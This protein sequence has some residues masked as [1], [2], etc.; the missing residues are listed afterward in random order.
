MKDSKKSNLPDIKTSLPGP[1]SK[2]LIEK[3][4]NL[5]GIKNLPN[6][7][8]NRGNGCII[9]D[10]DGNEF[11]VFSQAAC[12]TGYSNS[13]I[14]N[15]SI[16]Q[17]K[18]RII[19]GIAPPLIDCTEKLLSNLHGELS[20]GRVNFVVSGTESVELAVSFARA[21][22]KRPLILSYNDSHHG[23]IGTPFQL[24][25]DPR[26]KRS[27]RNKV[28]DIIYVPYPTCYRCPFKLE[29]Q[30]CDLLCFT[31]LDEIFETV[32]LPNQVAGIL[33]EPILVNGGAYVPPEDYVR[34][35]SDFCQQNGVQLIADEVYTGVGKSGKFLVIDHW[36]ITPDILCLGKAM[37]GGFPLAAVVTKREVTDNTHGGVRFTGT[38]QANLVACAASIATLEYIKK[39]HLT[40][41][42]TKIGNYLMES[43]KDLSKRKKLIGDVRGKGLL[44]GVDL[45]KD[46][47]SKT[48]AFKEASKIEEDAYKNGLLIRRVGRYRNVLLLG[49]PL[50]IN[51]EQ[52]ERAV[53]ILDNI[54]Y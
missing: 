27:W 53:E 15:A 17:T 2:I 36:K 25:G 6:I 47:E 30:D 29:Y 41:N 39:N 42:A 9:E 3:Y 8:A 4:A 40:E 45:V 31:Y 23:Y 26:I 21:Y 28:S 49:P 44:I 33:L 54:I 11:L 14:I 38:F 13:E 35:I 7:A 1:K 10:L 50:T 22:T 46:I 51:Q 34:K 12:V 20:Q 16:E 37:G 48:P 32:A 19:R 5:F 52:A 18:R 43:I 24:S